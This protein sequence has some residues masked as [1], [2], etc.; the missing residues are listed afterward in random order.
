MRLSQRKDT[1]AYQQDREE[2]GSHGLGTGLAAGLDTYGTKPDAN[3]GQVLFS[4]EKTI[5]PCLWRIAKRMCDRRDVPAS[6]VDEVQD[7][8]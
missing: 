4:G 1:A 7:I 2:A 6:R 8:I 3:I 5:E